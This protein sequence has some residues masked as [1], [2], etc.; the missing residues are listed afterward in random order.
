LTEISLRSSL[1]HDAVSVSAYTTVDGSVAYD[2][3]NIKLKLAGFNL[4]NSRSLID[5]DGTYYVFQVGRQI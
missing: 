4:G 5:F 2:F 3:G 1:G